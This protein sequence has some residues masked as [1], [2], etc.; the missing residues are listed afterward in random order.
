MKNKKILFIVCI[1][2]AI[3]VFFLF[4]FFSASP[5]EREKRKLQDIQMRISDEFKNVIGKQKIKTIQQCGDMC[6][7]LV[8]GNNNLIIFL[9]NRKDHLISI[10]NTSISLVKN[11][12]IGKFDIEEQTILLI[13]KEKNIVKKA[14]VNIK[15]PITR[16]KVKENYNVELEFP[17]DITVDSLPKV[18]GKEGT[19]VTLVGTYSQ[20]IAKEQK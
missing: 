16:N 6:Y 2:C 12:T 15:I 18:N 3:I 1:I 9:Y 19:T 11:S 17:N 20:A 4:F 14:V 13:G 10:N 5:E 8:L 7:K